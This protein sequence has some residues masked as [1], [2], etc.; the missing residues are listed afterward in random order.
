M[1]DLDREGIQNISENEMGESQGIKHGKN[2]LL[3]EYVSLPK[4]NYLY[5]MLSVVR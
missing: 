3:R 1:S 2:V 5:L 4:L